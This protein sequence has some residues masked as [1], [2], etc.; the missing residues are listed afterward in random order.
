MIS[1]LTRK[2]GGNVHDKAIVTILQNRLMMIT[3]GVLCGISL[4]S[5][6]TSFSAECF[7]HPGCWDFHEMRVRPTHY[8]IKTDRLRSWMLESSL[9]FMNWTE[10]D[11]KTDN[12]DFPGMASFAVSTSAECRFIRLTQ[13]SIN[14]TFDNQLRMRA[15]KVF[16]TLLE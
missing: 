14:V 2:H 5:L 7:F 9:N 8:T 13:T 3:P 12:S 11:R 6:M 1:Y 10:I 15:F 16:G 4:I